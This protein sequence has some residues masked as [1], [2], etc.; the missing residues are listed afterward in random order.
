MAQWFE[1][2]CSKELFIRSHQDIILF[3]GHKN[4]NKWKKYGGI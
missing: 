3:N 4:N 2:N 1:M